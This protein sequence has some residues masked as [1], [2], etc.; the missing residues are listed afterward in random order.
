M[1]R[2]RVEW[3]FRGTSLILGERTLLAGILNVTPDSFSD[4]GRYDDPDAAAARAVALQEQGA[5]LIDIG[6]ESTRPGSEPIS[7]A[8]ELRRLIPVLKRLKGK[9]DIP[10]SVDTYKPAVAETAIEHGA[11]IINDVS[12]LAWE[13]DLARTVRD[14]DAGLILSHTRGK[15]EEWARMAPMRNVM[16]EIASELEASIHRAR[17]AGIEADH[18]VIDPGIGFGKRKEQ[19]SELIARLGELSR[20]MLPILIGPSRK[21]F[22]NQEDPALLDFA[23]AGAVA[24]AIWNGAS[25][26]RV[27]DVAAMKAAAG[28]VDEIVRSIPENDDEPRDRRAVRQAIRER[29]Q[30]EV[31][32]KKPVRPPLIGGKPKPAETTSSAGDRPAYSR[33]FPPREETERPREEPRRYPSRDRESRPPRDARPARGGDQSRD[34]GEKRTFS[35]RGATRDR[36]PRD[37]ESRPPRD[38]RPARGGDQSR[39]RGDKRTFSDRGGTRDRPPRERSAF[40]PRDRDSRQQGKSAPRDRDARRS[41]DRPPR[42]ERGT[43]R[44]RF[45]GKR[46]DDRPS[47]GGKPPSRGP[48]GP[49]RGSGPRG[50]SRGPSTPRRR[51]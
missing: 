15:P 26:I 42:D 27:H 3:K 21:L 4:G 24:A 38:A 46:D 12:G 10:I 47:G 1:T 14:G 43:E 36:P 40:P 7:E 13:P 49:D 32:R 41:S 51:D 25:I 37:R 11:A 30:Q 2:K 39:D 22:L 50:G 33:P 9:L 48:K 29:D 23:T 16:G 31:E 45:R 6:A 20:L 35:D 8:E 17:R 44:P 5:D 19:N 28:V 18:I 34:R